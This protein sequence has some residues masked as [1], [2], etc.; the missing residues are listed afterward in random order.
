MQQNFLKHFKV[1]KIVQLSILIGIEV[2]FFAFLLFNPLLRGS[3]YTNPSLFQLSSMMWF[4]MIFFFL[5]ILY[6]FTKMHSFTKNTHELNKVAY[7]DDMTGI[8]NRYSCDLIFKM[9]HN[10]KNMAEIGCG[11]MEISNLAKIND[12]NGHELGDMAIQDFCVILDEVGDSFGFVGRNSGNEFLVVIDDCTIEKME[13]FFYTLTTRLSKYNNNSEHV[14]LELSYSY[15]LN[16]QANATC[17]SDII[18]LAYKKL[19]KI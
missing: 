7:L 18:T 16:S 6:D 1:I 9:Y 13:A 2:I 14:S 12:K 8:P 15:I 17:F 5:C 19:H 4:L 3:V 10:E 11:I